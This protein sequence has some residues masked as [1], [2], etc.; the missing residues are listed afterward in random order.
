[1]MYKP[2]SFNLAN[3]CCA[4][5]IGVKIKTWS[6]VDEGPQGQT[7]IIHTESV[8]DIIPMLSEY[9]L[10]FTRNRP[11]EIDIFTESY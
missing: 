7:S 9:F 8:E 4:V 2:S 3:L 5:K 6:E 10:N 1:M 11:G